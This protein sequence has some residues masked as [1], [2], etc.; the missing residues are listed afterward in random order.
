MA[1]KKADREYTDANGHVHKVFADGRTEIYHNGPHDA[2]QEFMEITDA[3]DE[4]VNR[5][6]FMPW[7]KTANKV[8]DNLMVREDPTNIPKAWTPNAEDLLPVEDGA[9]PGVDFDD[10]EHQGDG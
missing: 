6:R 8:E 1:K 2:D 3:A 10:P 7:T 9:V 5:R 4:A